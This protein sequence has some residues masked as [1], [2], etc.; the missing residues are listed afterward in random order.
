MHIHQYFFFALGILLVSSASG[1]DIKPTVTKAENFVPKGWKL[2]SITHG[3][4]NRDGK[5]DAVLVIQQTG[6]KKIIRDNKRQHP[7]VRDTNPR[8]LLIAFKKG[9]AYKLVLKNEKILPG[10][11]DAESRCS[12]DVL[13]ENG[14]GIEISGGNLLVIRFQYGTPCGGMGTINLHR[15][16][17]HHQKN[18]FKLI[19]FSQYYQRGSNETQTS[20][21][22]SSGKKLIV[23]EDISDENSKPVKQWSRLKTRRTYDLQALDYGMLEA[24]ISGKTF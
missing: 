1:V 7:E 6:E 20:I 11:D 12:E 22:Y 16:T 5:K 21:D 8:A 2:F 19:G 23:S 14:G 17:F 18:R 4:L 15:Y 24:I 10:Q 9:N 13:N 3:D